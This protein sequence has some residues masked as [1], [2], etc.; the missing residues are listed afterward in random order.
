MLYALQKQR[1]QHITRIKPEL[2]QKKKTD[3]STQNWKII[4]LKLQQ[5]R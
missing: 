5:T 3:R 2:S 1:L 4:F